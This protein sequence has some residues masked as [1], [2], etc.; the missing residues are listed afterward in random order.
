MKCKI[1]G[2]LKSNKEEWTTEDHTTL[3]ESQNNY[4]K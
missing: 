1:K 2:I 4:A 3:D